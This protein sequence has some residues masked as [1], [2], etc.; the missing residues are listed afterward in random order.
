MTS[1]GV[2]VAVHLDGFTAAGLA[3]HRAMTSAGSADIELAMVF[4]GTRHD[5]DEYAAV[6]SAV[7]RT[8]PKALLI[9]CSA[10]GVLTG[11]EEVENAT[12]VAVLALGGQ[13]LPTPIHI[14]GVR[15]EPREAGARLG[16]EALAVLGGNPVGA[17]VAVLVD[18][19]ELDATDF[20]AGINDVAPQLIIT[21]AG[22]S[23]GE[24]GCR[25]FWKG[26]AQADTAVAL[27]F[28]PELHPSLGMTQGC[29]AVGDPQTITAVD[30]N[31]ILEIEGRP[32]VEALEKTLSNPNN[33]GLRQMTQHLLAGIGELG[34]GGRSDY[35]VR[36]FAIADSD[37]PAL[38]VY[39]PV[40]AG[41]TICFTLRDAIGAREDMKA[42]LDEQ[43]TG[44]GKEPPKFGMYFNCAG[45]GSALY[46]QAG[47]DPE[48]IQRRFGNLPLAGIES[49]FEIAPTCGKPRIHMFTGVLLL[50]G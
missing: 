44:R 28:P 38:A 40:R 47:L 36:P 20:V 23:G 34:A 35:V 21:G 2:G 27:V 14:P 37:R 15:A 46:G 33:P 12:A 50:A 7:A 45:R 42:M 32:A 19:A 43:A 6:L 8:L 25:V 13:P 9:G 11:A 10:T 30:G 29:Q 49:S 41:Q 24:S 18:P 3:A 16:R 31:L 39:E 5:D 17:A 22:A 26:E 4:A 48:L 1:A